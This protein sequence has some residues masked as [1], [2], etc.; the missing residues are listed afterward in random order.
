[1]RQK[2]FVAKT[3]ILKVVMI[4]SLRFSS[5]RINLISSWILKSVKI[6]SIKTTNQFH[7]KC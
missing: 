3:S 1:M 2:P 6:N 7:A 5:E 4:K